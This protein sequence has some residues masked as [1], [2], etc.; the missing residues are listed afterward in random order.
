VMA[1][2]IFFMSF[3]CISKIKTFIQR[4]A[5]RFGERVIFFL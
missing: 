3:I 1:R 5:K 4:E 2:R